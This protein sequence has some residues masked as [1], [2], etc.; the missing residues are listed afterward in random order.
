M[1]VMVV[2]SVQKVEKKDVRYI[3]VIA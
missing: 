1:F 3:C 2:V